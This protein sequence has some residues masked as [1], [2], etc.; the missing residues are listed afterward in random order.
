M[1]CSDTH[2]DGKCH[3]KLNSQRE[4]ALGRE[5]HPH[6]VDLIAKVIMGSGVCRHSCAESEVQ[7]SEGSTLE[8]KNRPC[9]KKLERR[10]KARSQ[11]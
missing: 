5:L 9:K 6:S 7:P 2:A 8:Q 3:H 11:F 4:H 1:L 10:C